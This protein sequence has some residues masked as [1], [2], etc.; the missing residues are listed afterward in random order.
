MD[1]VW[2]YR[3]LY[4]HHIPALADLPKKIPETYRYLPAKNFVEG[5]RHPD[6]VVLYISN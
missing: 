2:P 1:M 4:D 5:L 3:P 6:C